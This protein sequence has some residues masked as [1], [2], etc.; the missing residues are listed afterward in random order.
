MKLTARIAALLLLSL[1]RLDALAQTG[2]TPAERQLFLLTNEMRA[3]HHLPPFTWDP[4]LGRAAR[5]HAFRIATATGALE[6]QYPGEPELAVRA[7]RAGAHFDAV[8][9]NIARFASTPAGL[10]DA[11]MHT[12]P[13]RATLLAPQLTAIGIGI[14]NVDGLL[15]GVQ[16]FSSPVPP[17][18]R[19]SVETS[20]TRLLRH[21]GLTPIAITASAH[22][23]CEDG[24]NTAPG[25]RL[26][27]HWQ[28][29]G[30]TELPP[31]ILRELTGNYVSAG[32]GACHV[33]TGADGFTT[34]QVALLL[35]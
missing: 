2:A 5:L 19:D 8:S 31:S 10:L 14:A 33:I 23:A 7:A 15:S 1:A 34:A 22:S 16:D 9:E 24:A 29:A 20:V 25:A 4:A 11:W 17:L 13:H 6:H 3:A 21:A 35:Y 26:V 32:V 27:L 18:S 30:F 12:P 28:S